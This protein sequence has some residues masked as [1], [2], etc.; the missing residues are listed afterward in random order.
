MTTGEPAVTGANAE[1]VAAA[2]AELRE[3]V[4]QRHGELAHAGGFGPE[5]L[6]RLDRLDAKAHL[7]EPRPVSPRPL[8]GRLLVA[9][10]RVVEAAALRWYGRPLVE[11]QTAFNLAARGAVADLLAELR[12][13]EGEIARLERRLAALEDRLDRERPAP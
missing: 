6:A 7:A 8:V 1:R 12:L 5:D 10:R 3:A 13:R 9:W 11:Q 2:L 4:R